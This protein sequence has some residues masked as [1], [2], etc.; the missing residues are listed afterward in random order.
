MRVYTHWAQVR[1]RL[2]KGALGILTRD[3]VVSCGLCKIQKNKK[4]LCFHR[5]MFLVTRDSQAMKKPTGWHGRELSSLKTESFRTPWL[6]VAWTLGVGCRGRDGVLQPC[7]RC[8][9]LTVRSETLPFR[10]LGSH[11]S[12]WFCCSLARNLGSWF[13]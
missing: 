13:L 4:K 7:C 11:C 1:V 2:G 8:S 6:G 10:Q 3:R 9:K 12:R 5:C